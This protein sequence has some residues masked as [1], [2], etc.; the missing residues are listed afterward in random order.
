MRQKVQYLYIEVKKMIGMFPRMLLQAIMLMVLIGT[1]AFC[2][3][4]S[5]EKDPLAIQV[6]IGVVVQEDNV[7]TQMALKYVENLESASQ[8][9]HFV[10]MS[11]EEGIHL[12]ENG[13][14]AA[15]IVLP[16]QLV[17]GIMNGTNPSVQV[18]FPQNAGLEAMLLRELTESGA[19]LL[20]VA[21][22]QIYG[23]YDTAV[24]YGMTDRL[25]VMQGEIDSYNL[26]FALDRLAVYEEETVSATGRMNMIQFYGASAAILFLL[27]TG[28]AVYPV[29]QREPQAF[30]KQLI[31]QGTGEMW[32]CFCKWL[33][34]F[35]CMGL[36]GGAVWITL[37]VAGV[38]LPESAGMVIAA[39]TKGRGGSHMAA[40]AGEVILI[41]ITVATLVYFIYSLSDGRTGA[42]LLI[43]LISVTMLYLSGGLVPSIFLPELVQAIGERLPTAYLIRAAGS[44]L[45]GYHADT[46]RQC[47][48]GMCCYTVVFGMAAYLFRRRD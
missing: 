33:C 35:F 43:F 27:L 1:I 44:I 17:E 41:V 24:T 36:L 13:E 2:G 9:C 47:T 28:M 22:A 45:T 37:K 34:G 18:C 20:R 29:M 6:K 19:G 14:I 31:R 46:F 15:L 26:A 42:V 7:M 23:A 5:M 16:E 10:Q 8:V 30:R 25:S 48:V 38:F 4:M 32:Q 11:Q 21:Q 12:L 40:Q 39:L 3:A